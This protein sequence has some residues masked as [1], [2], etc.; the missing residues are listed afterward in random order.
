MKK[1]LNINSLFTKIIL[2]VLSFAV[3][4]SIFIPYMNISA[5]DLVRD[6]NTEEKT[7]DIY[8]GKNNPTVNIVN[9]FNRARPMLIY[10]DEER[11]E[12][13]SEKIPT[14]NQVNT[15]WIE[16][17]A[18]GRDKNS[19]SDELGYV[20]VGF[21]KLILNKGTKDETKC[22]ISLDRKNKVITVNNIPNKEEFESSR[23]I[24]TSSM[25]CKYDNA[26]VRVLEK[27]ETENEVTNL[28]L[29]EGETK[30][31]FIAVSL[32]SEIDS[33]G[34]EK[35]VYYPLDMYDL[36]VYRDNLKNVLPTVGEIGLGISSLQLSAKK[37][38]ATLNNT[39]T[40]MFV[41]LIAAALSTILAFVVPAKFKIVSTIIS[42]ILGLGLIVVP[43][44]DYVLFFGPNKFAFAPGFFILIALG[45]LILLAAAFNFYR[46]NDE[47]RKEQIRLYGEDVFKKKKKN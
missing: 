18:Y 36:L 30:R 46:E 40:Y 13:V 15:Y 7:I 29:Q 25:W 14:P 28:S 47:Y 19:D 37:G 33:K 41:F 10:I 39:D 1:I 8:I 17:F 44:L 20:S 23:I 11:S 32:R 21:Y 22:Q 2:A 3:I 45:V 4:I 27:R 31:M 12:T 26:N 5:I 6:I 9:E 34:E 16:F 24:N 35:E 38:A 42:A 43:V